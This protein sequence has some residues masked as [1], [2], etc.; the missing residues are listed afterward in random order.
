M[1]TTIWLIFGIAG[2]HLG[3]ALDVAKGRYRHSSGMV[4]LIILGP[5]LLL[6]AVVEA[7]LIAIKKEKP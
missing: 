2:F 4:W 1:S 6:M 7:I 5:I 3:D